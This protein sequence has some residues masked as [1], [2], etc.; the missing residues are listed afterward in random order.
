MG[1]F[2]IFCKETRRDLVC[3]RWYHGKQ[4]GMESLREEC[5]SM[6][7]REDGISPRGCEYERISRH[8][9]YVESW[10]TKCGVVFNIRIKRGLAVRCGILRKCVIR[11]RRTF[12][13]RELVCGGRDDR[14]TCQPFQYR[15]TKQGL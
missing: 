11:S 6:E 12:Q 9:L 8:R 7:G 1:L 2:Q 14:W 3:G 10:T 15:Q 4:Q 5:T 13:L